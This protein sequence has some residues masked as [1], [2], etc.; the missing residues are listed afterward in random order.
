[1]N[2]LTLEEQR[3]KPDSFHMNYTKEPQATELNIQ[4]TAVE[5]QADTY[6]DGTALLTSSSS[7]EAL[8]PYLIRVK[9]GEKSL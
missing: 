7:Q 8:F 1:M 3:N 5:V 4:N 2:L 9:T 6:D